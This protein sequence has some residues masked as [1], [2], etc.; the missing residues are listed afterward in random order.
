M[1]VKG[2]KLS[3]NSVANEEK[4]LTASK[5]VT[6]NSMGRREIMILLRLA[7]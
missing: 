2:M 1:L 3:W 5:G 7:F 4:G 6:L